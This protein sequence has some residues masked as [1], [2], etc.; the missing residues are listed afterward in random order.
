MIKLPN[1][2]NKKLFEQA[3]IHRSYLNEIKQ[4]ASSN[5]RLEFLGDSILSFVVSQYLYNKYP[6][7]DEGTLTNL[8]SMLVNTKH[9]SQVA[10]ELGF[11]NLLKLSKGEE[12]SKGRENVSLLADCFEAFIGALYLDLGLEEVTRFIGTVI[13]P[14]AEVFLQRKALKDP[15]SLLQEFIQAKKQQSP[16]YTVVKEEG[17]PHKKFFTV[18]VSVREKVLGKGFGKSKQEAEKDA[19]KKALEILKP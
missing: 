12:E 9:L 13:L 6:N 10:K 1:F 15:K 2:K 17:P 4:K 14:E 7:F 18:E 5:E 8:R 11:G 19:A 16:V 3:F